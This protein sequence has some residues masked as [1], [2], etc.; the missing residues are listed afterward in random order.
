[1][2]LPPDLAA[3]YGRLSF[4]TRTDRPY[5]IS[6]FVSTIDGV[7]A[8]DAPGK[9]T[10]DVISGSNEQ[11]S[12]VMGLLRSVA[13]AVIVGAGTLRASPKHI[14]TAEHIY[15]PL[16]SA[17]GSLRRSVTA[18]PTPLNVVVTASGVLDHSM[19]V[20]QSGNVPVLIITTEAGEKLLKEFS[21]LATVKV[22][23]PRKAGH[24][25][26]HEIFAAIAVVLPSAKIILVEGGPHLMGE[27]FEE[28]W[29]D[30][31]FL[32]LAPHVAG[33]ISSVERLGIVAQKI[34]AP[35]NPLW[36]TLV[37]VKREGSHL[38]LRYAF[39]R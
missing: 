37:S 5:I 8:L 3:L 26:V 28:G 6:N 27:L 24:L 12:A 23:A 21:H 34:F 10:G 35:H 17:Y 38:F 22:I 13:D 29:M 33:R 1:L 36:A 31:L 14:W 9:A 2:I 30:E 4:P 20:F 15:P 39:E 18:A 25:T 11:D 32:T 19:P 16:N 7:V